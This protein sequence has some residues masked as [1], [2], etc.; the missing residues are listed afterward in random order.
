MIKHES[1]TDATDD[2]SLDMNKDPNGRENKEAA[3]SIASTS[4]D[5]DSIGA[6]KA[7]KKES[8]LQPKGTDDKE[9]KTKPIVKKRKK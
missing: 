4:T 7:V 3:A 6:A 2:K 5:D 8:S 1:H 9:G